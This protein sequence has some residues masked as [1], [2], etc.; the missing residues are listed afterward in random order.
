MPIKN[1]KIK[2]VS[3]IAEVSRLRHYTWLRLQDE[4]LLGMGGG[5]VGF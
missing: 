1:G 3:Q 5:A 4:L 2:G